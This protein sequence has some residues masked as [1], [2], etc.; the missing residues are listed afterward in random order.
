MSLQPHFITKYKVS[1]PPAAG[2][3]LDP[4]SNHYYGLQSDS[5][6]IKCV[7]VK[8]CGCLY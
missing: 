7:L 5:G 2:Q 8:E 6:E 4:A 1:K 3:T